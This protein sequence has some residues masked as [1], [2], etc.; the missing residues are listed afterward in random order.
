MYATDI[1]GNSIKVTGFGLEDDP[2]VIRGT[3]SNPALAA[4]VEEHMIKICFENQRWKLKK[5]PTS[6][7]QE[8]VVAILDI[9]VS[10]DIE[11]TTKVEMFFDVTEV[12]SSPKAEG[13]SDLYEN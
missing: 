2:F 10:K 3:G 9:L 8:R 5:S 13:I 1:M 4:L 12:F 7:A 6:K 11:E